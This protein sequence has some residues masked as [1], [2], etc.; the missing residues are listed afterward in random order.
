MHLCRTSRP[1]TVTSGRGRH[2]GPRRSIGGVQ[3]AAEERLAAATGVVATLVVGVG[4]LVGLLTDGPGPDLPGSWWVAYGVFVLALLADADPAMDA[5][6]PSWLSARVLVAVQVV[7]SVAVW[8]SQP[9][10]GWT[11]VLFV[12]SAVSAAYVV[13]RAA[14]A[15]VIAVQSLAVAV[16][17]ALVGQATADVVLSTLMYATFQAFA[18]IVVHSG[19]REAE[20]KAALAA[21]HADLR[22][23]ST[24]LATTA[25]DAERLRISRELHDVV[26]HQLTA[27]AL[28]LEVASHRVSGEEAEHVTRARSIAK[29][30]LRDVRATVSGLRQEVQG[31]EAALHDVVAGTPG[32]QVELDVDEGVPVEQADVLV[33]VRCVQECVTNALRH[34]AARRLTVRVRSDDDGVTLEAHDDGRGAPRLVLGNGLTGMTERVEARGGRIELD[35]GVGRG[36]A[37]TVRIPA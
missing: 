27:L 16:G 4:G 26:G 18:T 19:R 17:A 5:R 37:V 13:G 1:A 33:L 14:T 36:F 3:S 25:R 15:V 34:A 23:A 31:L 11:A 22:A 6:R 7:A 20:S 21:A 28:E 2:G 35:P 8:F 12:V 32:L 24:L 29:D 9:Q 10:A 30:L